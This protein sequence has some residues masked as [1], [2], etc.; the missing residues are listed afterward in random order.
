M[1][2]NIKRIIDHAK[3]LSQADKLLPDDLKD[4][5][6]DL[7]RQLGSMVRDAHGDGSYMIQCVESA[8]DLA[9]ADVGGTENRFLA[10]DLTEDYGFQNGYGA[11]Q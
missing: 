5:A 11:F 4:F 2:Q 10:S 1:N 9:F 6:R 7:D 8:M 3:L